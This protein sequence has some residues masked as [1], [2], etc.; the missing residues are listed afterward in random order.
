MHT[1]ELSLIAPCLIIIT[2]TG[3]NF[4]EDKK[5]GKGM[6]SKTTC[7]SPAEGRERSMA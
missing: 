2:G 4:P 5:G 6:A 3:G 1:T 7:V